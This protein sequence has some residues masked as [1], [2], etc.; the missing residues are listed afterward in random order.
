MGKL[1]ALQADI[2]EQKVVCLPSQR[3]NCDVELHSQW[4]GTVDIDGAA[5]ARLFTQQPAVF[6]CRQ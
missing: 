1:V 5:Q 6:D 3:T 2:A 4:H